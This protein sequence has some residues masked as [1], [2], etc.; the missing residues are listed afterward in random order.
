MLPFRYELMKM[1]SE[2]EWDYVEITYEGLYDTSLIKSER[3]GMKDIRYD[4]PYC[5]IRSAIFTFMRDILLIATLALNKPL[6]RR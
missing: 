6:H 2:D 1:P 4:D 3:R 5:Y